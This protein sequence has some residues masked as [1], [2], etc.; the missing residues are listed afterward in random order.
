MTTSTKNAASRRRLHHAPMAS[1]YSVAAARR[2]QWLSIRSSSS[3]SGTSSSTSRDP[4]PRT[5]GQVDNIVVDEDE[6]EKLIDGIEEIIDPLDASV[7]EQFMDRSKFTL[8]IPVRMPALADMTTPAAATTTSSGG[9]NNAAA[10]MGR[11]VQWNFRPGDIVQR[12][13]V[14]C[15]IES[16]DQTLTVGLEVDDEELAIM[17]SILVEAGQPVPVGDVICILYHE[18]ERA[19]KKNLND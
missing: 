15:D 3:S 19:A 8:E 11:V 1:E 4:L 2:R 17:G 6:D 10:A 12:E 5:A 14:L 9:G 16:P 18:E 13:D 7:L